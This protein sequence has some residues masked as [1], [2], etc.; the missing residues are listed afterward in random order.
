MTP[1][2]WLF[3]LFNYKIKKFFAV[4]YLR[5]TYLLSIVS[6]CTSLGIYEYGIARQ[7]DSSISLK[8]ALG[9][10]GLLGGI[11][12]ILIVRIIIEFLIA[13]FYIEEHLKHISDSK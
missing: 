12:A 3:E 10:A 13:I 11:T 1:L 5:V 4:D 2:D 7:L 6:V 8:I 9:L